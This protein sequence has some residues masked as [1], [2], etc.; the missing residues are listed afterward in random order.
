MT[1]DSGAFKTNPANS[2][3]IPAFYPGLQ[4]RCNLASPPEEMLADTRAGLCAADFLTSAGKV[5]RYSLTSLIRCAPAVS[6]ASRTRPILW[7]PRSPDLK[8]LCRD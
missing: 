1:E 5:L 6:A 7:S 3:Q 2:R 8:G 4:R